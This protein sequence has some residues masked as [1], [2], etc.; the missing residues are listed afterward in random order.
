[1][2]VCT[3]IYIYIYIYIYKHINGGTH[4]ALEAGSGEDI[5]LV[6]PVPRPDALGVRGFRH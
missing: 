6:A 1:M 4:L 3:Y 5:E 2:Y